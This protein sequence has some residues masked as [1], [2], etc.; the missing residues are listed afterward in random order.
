LIFGHERSPSLFFLILF[1]LKILMRESAIYFDI[2]PGRKLDYTNGKK[3]GCE[4]PFANRPFYV[5]I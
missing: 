4:Y 3:D 2:K 5:N 1:Y